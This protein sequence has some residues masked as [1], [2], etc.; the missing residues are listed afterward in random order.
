[1]I[2][3]ILPV[4]LC[5]ALCGYGRTENKNPETEAVKDVF[6]MNT[7]ITM[8]AYG[9]NAEFTLNSAKNRITELEALWSVT[10]GQSEIYR[11]NH[12]NG[13]PIIVSEPIA[14]LIGYALKMAEKTD[15]ALEPTIYPVLTAWGFTTDSYPFLNLIHT[16][17]ISFKV[18][19]QR[20]NNTSN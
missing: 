12:S 5:L 19:R 2:K 10:N 4:L 15:G 17:S 6:A 7:Y 9:E 11:L 1:M 20:N 18:I 14:K 16:L 8:K 3:R 13:A